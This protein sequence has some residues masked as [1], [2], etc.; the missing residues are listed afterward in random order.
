MANPADALF[1]DLR[2]AAQSASNADWL[3]SD[4]QPKVGTVE[5]VA[6]GVGAGAVK[7]VIGLTA[8]P[9]TVEQLGRMGINK[10]AKMAGKT[11]DAVSP[12]PALPTYT[13]IKGAVENRTGKLYEPQ[14]T[15]GQYAGTAAEFLPGMLFP[16][17]AAATVGRRLAG[18]AV[19]NVAAPAVVS[20]TAGQLTKGGDIEPYARMAGGLVGGV[21][22]QTVGRVIS[23][24]RIDPERTRQAAVLA[25]EGVDVTAGQV[26]GSKPLRYAE[27]VAVDTPFAGGRAAAAM[28]RQAEQFTRATLRRA[29]IDA[30]RAT[31]EVINTAFQRI[32][33]D[34]EQAA[35][36]VFVPLA[37]GNQQ[38]QIQP[39]AVVRVV[40]DIAARYER[41]SQPSLASPL[42]RR[43]SDDLAGMSQNALN[44]DGRTYLRWRSELG[45]AARGAQDAAT[46]RALYD[47][48]NALDTAAEAFLR[49]SRTPEV[50]DQ[51]RQ[52]R[53]Q[54]RNMIV[55]EKAATSAGE[56]AAIGLISPSA[57][58]AATVQQGRRA[59]A[60]GQGDFGNLARAGEA[61]MKPLPQSGTGP[62]VGVQ[63]LGT[64][65]GGALGALMGGPVT[66]VAGA[67]AGQ[68]FGPAIVGRAVMSPGI[69]AY[70]GNHLPFQNAAAQMRDLPRGSRWAPMPGVIVQGND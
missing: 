6:K 64:T 61:L 3:F 27:S 30:D 70:L 36:R 9:G 69:Q 4:L 2:P 31:P 23:P 47:I 5:D 48:Q 35:R 56:N 46:R 41:V 8:L 19:T 20:E 39:Q 33:N 22:P 37:R 49:R 54:Y 34:F 1:A 52:A 10:V 11:G 58:R 50:A 15:A 21:L 68:V 7:G 18:R 45:A 63:L 57:L 32:G 24:T 25:G 38:G 62:R 29:G 55:I 26:S 51:L 42:P 59:Y 66:G 13:D 65:V 60:S 67:T 17:G 53:N 28:D 14:T 16:G 40:D 44:M 12:E 43:I